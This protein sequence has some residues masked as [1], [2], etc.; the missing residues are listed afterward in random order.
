MGDL[1]AL[2]AKYHAPCLASLYKKAERVKGKKAKKMGQ[3]LDDQRIWRFAELLSFIEKSHMVSTAMLPVFRLTE[4]VGKYMS[5]LT[6]LGKNTPARIH[7]T[8]LKDRILSKISALEEH[9]QGRDVFFGAFKNDLANVLQNARKE[10]SA[11]EAMHLAKA[12]SIACKKHKVTNLTD[13]LKR[14]AR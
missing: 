8:R 9:K 7:S 6:Q 13:L 2:E 14:I 10:D 12:A 11:E 3:V 4:L 5:R 1:V